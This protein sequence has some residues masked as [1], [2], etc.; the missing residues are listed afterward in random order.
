MSRQ[1][2]EWPKTV[3]LSPDKSVQDVA[4]RIA[5]G[6]GKPGDI[7]SLINCGRRV[8]ELSPE[9]ADVGHLAVFPNYGVPGSMSS[10]RLVADARNAHGLTPVIDSG[11]GSGSVA[12]DERESV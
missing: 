3:A 9:V 11:G 12:G 10:N 2:A 6:A 1:L 7:A 4:I 8:P 5:G